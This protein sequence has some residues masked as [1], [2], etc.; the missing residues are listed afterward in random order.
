[1]T[2]LRT[3]ELVT[4]FVTTELNGH[5]TRVDNP[6]GVT[7]DQVGLGNVQNYAVASQVEAEAGTASNRYMTPLRTK[8]LMSIYV[9]AQVAAHGDLTDNPHDVTASQVGAYSRTESDTLM[10]K[11]VLLTDEWVAGKTKSAFITEV[12]AGTAA[13]A[14]KFNNKTYEQVMADATAAVKTAL[15]DDLVLRLIKLETELAGRVQALE[16]TVNSVTV[17]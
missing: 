15:T 3:K 12:L 16:D 6:H 8:Q 1:M 17:A 4:Q 9:A 5:A 7:A 2:P 11:Y 10:G 13:N 14:T